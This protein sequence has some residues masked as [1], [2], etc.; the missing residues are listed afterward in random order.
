MALRMQTN[1]GYETTMAISISGVVAVGTMYV[2][3]FSTEL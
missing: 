1:Y 2:Y 3:S